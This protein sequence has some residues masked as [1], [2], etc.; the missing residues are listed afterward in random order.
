VILEE[1]VV[2]EGMLAA[3]VPARIIRKLTDKEKQDL[4]ESAQRYVTYA[5]SFV[6]RPRQGQ[7]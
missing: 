7:L 6:D 2:P 3:G 5:A 1:F 4:F